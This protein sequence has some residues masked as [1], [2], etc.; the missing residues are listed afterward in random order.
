M[1]ATLPDTSALATVARQTS[2]VIETN[3][4][5]GGQGGVDT[6]VRSLERLLALLARQT[7]P[8]DALAEIIVTHDGI[9]ATTCARLAALQTGHLHFAQLPAD[10]GYYSA[11]NAGFAAMSPA[12]RYIAFADSDCM[13][14]EDWLAQLLAPLAAAPD[15]PAVA[16]R[17]SYLFSVAGAALTTIDFKYYDNPRY[18]QA[19]RNFYANNVVFQHELFARFAYQPLDGTYRGHCQ[20]FGLKLEQSGVEIRYAPA[21]HTVHRLPDSLG[22]LLRLR[23]MRGQDAC[24]LTPFLV[25]RHLPDWMQWFGRSGPVAPLVVLGFR[26][27]FS[28][29]A[30]NHQDLPPLRGLRRLASYGLILA[31]SAVDMAGALVRG[32]GWNTQGGR[33]GDSIA[34]SYHK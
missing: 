23:W 24:S 31:V 4:L 29:G 32:L 34:L 26:L 1:T 14:A 19:T 20:V 21:A 11:K 7:L 2:L 13:P 22:E 5:H 27:G 6:V 3:N 10:T 17:T 30:L 9:D 8:L 25:R 12:S 16:G 28:L 15:L 33:D 18:R